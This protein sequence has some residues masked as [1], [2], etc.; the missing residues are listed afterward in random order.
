MENKIKL[1][2]AYELFLLDCQARRLTPSTL[3][4]YQE[5]VKRLPSGLPKMGLTPLTPL[6]AIT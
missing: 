6:Q 4:F 1:N 2:D 3:I 5:K